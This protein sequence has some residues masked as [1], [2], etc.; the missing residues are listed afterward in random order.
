MISCRWFTYSG[1]GGKHLFQILAEWSEC[2]FFSFPWKGFG[3]KLY[4]QLFS[5]YFSF[6]FL[7]GFLFHYY[8][9]NLSCTSFVVFYFQ[10]RCCF[11][12]VSPVSLLSVL[13]FWSCILMP[14]LFLVF[15]L[16]LLY[17][18]VHSCVQLKIIAQFNILE[19]GKCQ[20]G[21][22]Y[23]TVVMVSWQQGFK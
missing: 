11:D 13:H 20:C 17:C 3:L 9:S 8:V 6:F 22:R 19:K 14:L 12:I 15:K 23:Q 4:L 10:H 16:Q 18:L 1:K 21:K 2:A 5:V 7:P